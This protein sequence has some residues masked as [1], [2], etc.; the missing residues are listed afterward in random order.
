VIRARSSPRSSRIACCALA[1]VVV[2]VT[3]PA[4]GLAATSVLS[5]IEKEEVGGAPAI[6]VRLNAPRRVVTYSPPTRGRLLEVR[7]APVV[8]AANVAT[9][10]ARR[11]SLSWSAD[12]VIPLSEV[13]YE[14]DALGGASL[15]LR[16][17]RE[18]AYTVAAGADFRSV[19]VSFL[20]GSV[21]ESNATVAA[22]AVASQMEKA[23]EA[24][25]AGELAT[26][27]AIYERVLA[28]PETEH[29]PVALE[30]LGLARER[31][32]QREA[33]R[34][35]YADYL[36]RYPQGEGA[37]RIGQRLAALESATAAMPARLREPKAEAGA[38]EWDVHG[39]V[40]QFYRRDDSVDDDEGAVFEDSALFNDASVT[41]RRR[42]AISEIR[43][44][45]EGGYVQDFE[46]GSESEID[47]DELYVDGRDRGQRFVAAMGRQVRSGGGIFGRYDGGLVGY[48][49][50]DWLA[51]N[52]V[53]GLASDY[54]TDDD[55]NDDRY[56]YGLSLDVGPFFGALSGSV[57]GI[58]Q[59]VD[60][61]VD[62][63]AVGGE[64]RYAERRL[65]AFGLLDYDIYFHELNIASLLGTWTFASGAS[66][67]AGYDE[68]LIALLTTSNALQGQTDDSIAD[69]RDT[70]SDGEIRDL[71][72]D[73]TA[74]SRSATLGGALPLSD[75]WQLTTDL[76][77]LRLRGTAASGGVE[78]TPG[79]GDEI[80]WT[81]QVIGNDLL[82]TGDIS[83]LALR[84]SDTSEWESVGTSLTTRLPI[85][86]RWRVSPRFLFDYRMLDDGG[87]QVVVRP[88]TRLEWTWRQSLD[89]ELEVGGE[90]LSEEPDD[91]SEDT[92]WGYFVSVGYRW[93]F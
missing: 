71:A 37:E 77:W 11:E 82:T 76:T 87:D 45:F 44:R 33:A 75:F 25:L 78:A 34:A 49:V 15:V 54:T 12:S 73:R 60:G 30:L 3:A 39:T 69:M 20:E 67:T 55:V 10:A 84:C 68:R 58:E 91:G 93:S 9:Q 85:G 16:F 6:R 1:I 29:T 86:T 8:P 66:L 31:S 38:A 28:A 19:V 52:A 23:S 32:D 14:P 89:L 50:L 88:A 70:Y 2:A 63:R 43:A 83:A 80:Y 64:I 17:S 90:W 92:P 81:G 74:R 41:A 36:R 59:R 47:V 53:G 7:L 22:D 21:A 42:S 46:D 72:R 51:V 65:S 13:V 24:M 61:I 27:I 40:E 26:A 62:R 57:Y 5:R 4:V 48:R 79:S 35:A 56:L 18:I